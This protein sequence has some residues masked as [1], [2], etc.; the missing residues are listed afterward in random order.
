M[1]IDKDNLTE[2]QK[3]ALEIIK[4]Q[5]AKIGEVFS[6]C[7][8]SE[9]FKKAFMEDPKAIF[10]EY[11]VNYNKKKEYKVLDTPDKTVIHVLPYEGI[12]AGL[13]DMY[14]R[15]NENVKDLGDEEGK[16][17]IPEGWTYQ[18]V[19]NTEDTIYFPIPLSPENLTPEELELV[20]GGCLILVFIIAVEALAEVTTSVNFAW[21]IIA[22]AAVVGGLFFV[23]AMESV[24]VFTTAFALTQAIV[25]DFAHHDNKNNDGKNQ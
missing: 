16:A 23:E 7:W 6:Q 17:I 24:A 3:K 13:K 4:D 25:N 10:D 22:V 2:D 19:Q 18:I 8:E 15:L 1:A 11:G 14:D 20:N 12:K 21:A 9:E 5:Q